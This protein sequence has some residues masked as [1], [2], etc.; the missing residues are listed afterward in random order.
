MAIH[1]ND[2]Y[3]RWMHHTF[4]YCII[5]CVVAHTANSFMHK[6][7]VRLNTSNNAISNLE[8]K[9]DDLS[10]NVEISS[11]LGRKSPTITT[12]LKAN[13]SSDM[14]LVEVVV[15]NVAVSE[16]SVPTMSCTNLESSSS[17]HSNSGDGLFEN[18]SLE[19]SSAT[20]SNSEHGQD[21]SSGNTEISSL[22]GG[23]R[24]YILGL[25][26]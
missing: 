10:T 22:P 14:E 2:Q 19:S 18:I 3:C 7:R 25:S 17:I 1:N 21:N 13:I 4:K 20:E 5:Q 8:V 24:S 9:K 12:E 16:Q 11:F 6:R 26:N 15:H 23:Q